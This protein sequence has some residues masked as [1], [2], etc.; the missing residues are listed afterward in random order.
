MVHLER[1]IIS[2]ALS[3]Y[4]FT[5]NVKVWSAPVPDADALVDP[6]ERLKDEQAGVLNEVIYA[7]DQE[8]IIHQHLQQQMPIRWLT[9]RGF[10]SPLNDTILEILFVW[11]YVSESCWLLPGFGMG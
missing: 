3:F 2:E 8:E 10:L 5:P 6:D 4:S 1:C 11:H 9:G 7:G